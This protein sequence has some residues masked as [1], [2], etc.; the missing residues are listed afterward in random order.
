MPQPRPALS[1]S[2]FSCHQDMPY[3]LTTSA[4]CPHLSYFK[5]YIYILNTLFVFYFH[6]AI[7]HLSKQPD[8]ASRKQAAKH[9]T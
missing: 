2:D 7:Y 9:S 5:K 4:I 3:N 1:A 8:T 6:L